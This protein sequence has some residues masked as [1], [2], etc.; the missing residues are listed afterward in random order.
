MNTSHCVQ[1]FHPQN[2][3]SMVSVIRLLFANS[4]TCV[5]KIILYNRIIDFMFHCKYQP[6]PQPEPN[7][8]FITFAIMYFS[9]LHFKVLSPYLK[10]YSTLLDVLGYYLTIAHTIILYT[11][12]A[13]KTMRIQKVGPRF[14]DNICTVSVVHHI[15]V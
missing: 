9:N 10:C 13:R 11:T 4:S 2:C 8:D 12:Q 1:S 6:E 15:I 14:R 3:Q 5:R 7:L